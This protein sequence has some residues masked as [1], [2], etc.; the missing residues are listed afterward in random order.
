MAKYSGKL[1]GNY[2]SSMSFNISIKRVIDWVRQDISYL[3]KSRK[4][5]EYAPGAIRALS[6][7][8]QGE[9]CKHLIDYDLYDS[10]VESWKNIFFSWF[11]R[12]KRHYGEEERELFVKNAE[13]D[14]KILLEAAKSGPKEYWEEKSLIRSFP[15]QFETQ[16]KLDSARKAAEIK[17]PVELGSAIHKYIYRCIDELFEEDQVKESEHQKESLKYQQ[18]EIT[19]PKLMRHEDGMFSLMLDNFD[20]FDEEEDIEQEILLN[21]YN[22]DNAIK[23]YFTEHKD[24]CLNDLNFD[25]ESSLFC[26]R[27]ANTSS[28]LKVTELFYKFFEDCS[29]R[30]KYLRSN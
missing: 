24:N 12:V 8:C 1:N 5:D 25:S 10:E 11:N 20:A 14:F 3:A 21:G 19:A 16:E 17:H 29:L 15:I 30:R 2:N 7:I 27:S 22:V 9:K 13:N 23:S 4:A 18:T 6:K 26:V 28:L